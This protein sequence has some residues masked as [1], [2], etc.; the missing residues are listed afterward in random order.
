MSGWTTKTEGTHAHFRPKQFIPH[1]CTLV[2]HWNSSQTPSNDGKQ[3]TSMDRMKQ[4]TSPAACGLR[5]L[6]TRHIWHENY[7]SS[8]LACRHLACNMKPNIWN[9]GSTWWYASQQCSWPTWQPLLDSWPELRDS[10]SSCRMDQPSTDYPRNSVPTWS[11]NANMQWGGL[12][13]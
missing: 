11:M 1:M 9:T 10:A 5:E 6:C 3:A 12:I 13:L 4:S 2:R 8:A 7:K